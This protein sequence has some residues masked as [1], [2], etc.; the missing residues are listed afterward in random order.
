MTQTRSNVQSVHDFFSEK[1][2]L[3]THIFI[4][5]PNFIGGSLVWRTVNYCPSDPSNQMD[6]PDELD[7]RKKT[8]LH[9]L[10]NTKQK[11]IIY[12][13]IKETVT[14]RVN[15]IFKTKVS[16]RGWSHCIGRVIVKERKETTEEWPEWHPHAVLIPAGAFRP[17]GPTA[18]TR[19]WRKS[20]PNDRQLNPFQKIQ[21]HFIKSKLYLFIYLRWNTNVE[22]RRQI[23]KVFKQNLKLF[24]AILEH[25]LSSFRTMR[26][27]FNSFF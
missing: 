4:I 21:M 10:W 5:I 20:T 17:P 16:K 2:G 3:V 13:E 26:C 7:S 27:L 9:F 24:D 15:A 11:E 22:H 25:S 8:W 19:A 18:T 1:K 6:P 14:W 23:R 12:G